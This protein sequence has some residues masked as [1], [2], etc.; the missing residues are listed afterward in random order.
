VHYNLLAGDQPDRTAVTL[1][2]AAARPGIRALGT[3]LVP[4]PVEL[5]CR[6]DEAGPLCSRP[7]A[8]R[9]VAAR[10]GPEIGGSAAELQRFCGAGR[11]RPG[12]TQHCDIR[13]PET[14]TVW[15][16]AGHMHL[17][18]RSIR[19]TLD[20]G[21]PRERVILDVPVYDFDNQGARP[22]AQ[23]IQLRK[24]H[25]VRVT[26]TH[27]A[28]LRQLLPALAH[29]PPRYVVWGDGTSDEMCLGILEVTRG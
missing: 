14:M 26:C 19:L 18:G 27:D 1:R 6:P 24:G 17:L 23:P 9:D 25:T 4:A 2:L 29:Q 3:A 22:L 16:A 12:P 21:T 11:P 15:A 13:V 7:A 10:F 20:P 5:P 28:R 8:I